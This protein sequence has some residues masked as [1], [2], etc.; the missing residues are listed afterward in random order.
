MKTNI[1]TKSIFALLAVVIFG[2]VTVSAFAN[3][4]SDAIS[5]TIAFKRG[6]KR[7]DAN[8]PKREF[9]EDWFENRIDTR[10]NY[11][12]Y[13]QLPEKPTN[14]EMLEFFNNYFMGE[15][16]PRSGRNNS[17]RSYK[18]ERKADR[19]EDWFEDR[20][21]R[22]E[23]RVDF[24]ELPENPTDEEIV[25]FFKKYFMDENGTVTRKEQKRGDKC[26]PYSGDKNTTEQTPVTAEKTVPEEKVNSETPQNVVTEEAPAK[27]QPTE[28]TPVEA[29]PTD[30]A[31]KDKA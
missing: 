16:T 26:E 3:T 17:Q 25:E 28:E 10:E 8:H 23:H 7:N 2:A 4:S 20:I 31:V 24:S 12:D 11:V 13:S 1:L 22:H 6:E 15:S 18:D 27:T 21:E 30:E 19:F 5:E 29:Q 9:F 14:E